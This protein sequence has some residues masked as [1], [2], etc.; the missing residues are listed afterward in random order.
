MSPCRQL[1]YIVV[2]RH[3][4]SRTPLANVRILWFLS[5]SIASDPII[6]YDDSQVSD[7]Q[8]STTDRGWVLSSCSQVEDKGKSNDERTCH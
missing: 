2:N 4:T 5:I 1:K 6:G 8:E 3:R 7:T